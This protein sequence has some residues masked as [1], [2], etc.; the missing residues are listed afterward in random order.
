MSIITLLPADNYKVINKTI[1]NDF[2]RRII[3]SFYA[4]IIGPVAT[5]LYLILWQ[6][7]EK[8]ELFSRNLIH[9]HLMSILKCNLKEI[10]EARESLE[11]LGLVK[12]Y[13]K[14]GDINEYVYELY[15]P[16]LPQEFFNHPVLNVVLYNNI[17]REEYERLKVF[18][19]K[20]KVDT[21][22]YTE[23]TKNIDEVYKSDSFKI[24]DD[25]RNRET[26]SLNVSEKIDYDML[27]S[28]M[29]KGV[30]NEKAFNKKTKELINLL[31]F[32]YDLDTNKMVEIVRSVLNEFGMIDKSELRVAVRKHYQFKNNA[33]PT[34]V[35]R[36]QPEYLKNPAGDNSMKGK[37]I[38]LFENTTPYDFIKGKNKG[39]KPTNRDLKILELLLVDLEL[40][41]AVVNVL[42]DYVL[43]KNNN[44]LTNAY[45]ETIASQWKRADLKTAKEAME[46]AE[47]EH[48]K[49]SKKSIGN[50]K[51]EI[52]VPV[53]FDEN[54]KKEAID[55][56][57]EAELKDLLKEFK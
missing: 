45:V 8:L 28:A 1:L 26:K 38:A 51:K 52:K 25:S 47:K 37:I 50:Q 32:I 3:V 36:A 39:V 35:Y 12:T 41:P 5:N 9:H 33:L 54:I 56:E 43:R 24:A 15:S 17:G 49:Y 7:L 27:L 21:K 46:F 53:W 2:D 42:I 44:R 23:I 30:I 34:L 19:Q 48:K 57:E 13:V 20:I 6:D 10:K 29:P 11:A 31:A 18:Y 40:S 22:E 4:P 16:L 14:T 55:I